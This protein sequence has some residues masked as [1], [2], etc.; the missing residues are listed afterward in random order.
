MAT[1]PREVIKWLQSLDLSHSVTRPRRD[2]ANGVLVAEILS[3]YVTEVPLH[4]LDSSCGTARKVDNWRQLEKSLSKANVILD[5]DLVDGTIQ[6]REGASVV[7]AAHGAD[8]SEPPGAA[9]GA[10]PG[11][12][13]GHH[14]HAEGVEN[15]S[16]EK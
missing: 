2:V 6:S 14:Q 12:R 3:R 7:H 4:G 1:L 13:G 8:D 11:G 5:T 9:P 10:A 16:H 15:E